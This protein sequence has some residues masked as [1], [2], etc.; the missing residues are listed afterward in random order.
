MPNLVSK[1]KDELSQWFI[2]PYVDYESVE[3]PSE[4]SRKALTR[5][6]K[7]TIL[8]YPA[9]K[10]VTKSMYE[11]NATITAPFEFPVALKPTDS[12]E[13]LNIRFEGRKK[14]FTIHSQVELTNTIAKIYDNGYTSD[15][16][17]CRTL[18]RVMTAT[19][20]R[21][22]LLCGPISSRQNDV[23]WVIRYLRIPRQ[24]P[25]GTMSRSCRLSI[26]HL[27]DQIKDIPRSHQVH[28]FC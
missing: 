26:R 9:T 27:Y 18:Y 24:R 10:I 4:R 13:W 3:A 25:S 2:C 1:H 19:C 8:P 7:S 22:E 23:L 12:V 11:S 21:S 6:A 14:A 15:L 28:R 5:F 20:G 17:S 16:N